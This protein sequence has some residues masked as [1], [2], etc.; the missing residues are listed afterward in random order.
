MTVVARTLYETAQV[1]SAA[2]TAYTAPV[3]TRTI[4]DKATVTNPTAGALT[5]TAYLVPSGGTAGATNAVISVQSVAAGASYLCPELVG[6]VLNPGD[7]LSI[8]ASAA[9]SLVFRVSGR[10]VS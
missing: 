9:T 4:L 6:H 8:V 7:F 2:T 1:P 10:E 5:F 3:N